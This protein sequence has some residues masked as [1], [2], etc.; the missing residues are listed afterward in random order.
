M[1]KLVLEAHLRASPIERPS[2]PGY[3][4]TTGAV[5]ANPKSLRFISE[6]IA[7]FLLLVFQLSFL[8][9]RMLGLPDT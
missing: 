9:G 1:T 5:R 2:G 7:R 8:G 6:M 3:L 4:A